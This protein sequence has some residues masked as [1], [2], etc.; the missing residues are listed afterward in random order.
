MSRT[1]L[2][3]FFW[4]IVLVL[5]QALIFNHIAVFGV[6]MPFV[7][8]YLIMRLPLTLGR[9]WVLTIGF[10]LGL[11]VDV[12]SDTYGMNSL[13]TTVMAVLRLPVLRIYFPREQELAFPQPSIRAIG[14]WP[15]AK[16][17]LTLSFV[18]CLTLCLVESFTFFNPLQLVARVVGS[19]LLT[20]VIIVAIDS[21]TLRRNEKRL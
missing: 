3:F 10:L 17:V 21:I 19:T 8:I 13:A 4:G 1:F 14:F 11:A 7:F 5:S 2:T 16:Y 20:T 18:F 9:N 6:A 12:F 15:F